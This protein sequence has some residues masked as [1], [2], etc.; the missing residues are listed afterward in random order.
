[1]ASIYSELF[2]EG[3]ATGASTLVFTVPSDGS[4]YILRDVVLCPLATG[5]S[6]V[7]LTSSV[8]I[9]ASQVTPDEFELLHLDMRQVLVPGQDINLDLPSGTC[10]YRLSG[11]RLT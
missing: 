8:A 1:M 3:V 10:S 7:L 6:Q 4:V 9:Y 2:A 11:Y 5:I